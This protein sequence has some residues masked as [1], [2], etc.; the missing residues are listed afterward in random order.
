MTAY[1]IRTWQTL[2]VAAV[3]I[4][5]AFVLANG[6]WRSG[7]WTREARALRAEAAW[8]LKTINGSATGSRQQFNCW[9]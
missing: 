2:A 6:R 9:N 4:L 3:L 5:A 1:V 8:L 7:A